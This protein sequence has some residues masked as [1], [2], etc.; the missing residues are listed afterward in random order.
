M[1]N[2]PASR[3]QQGVALIEVLVAVLI[4]SFGLLG[5]VGLQS[6]A[7][8]FSGNSEDRTIAASLA[9]EAAAQMYTLRTA[10]DFTG[11]PLT[12]WK[13]KVSDPLAGG[14]PG[15]VG[16]VTPVAATATTPA[17]VVIKVTWQPVNSAS[18]A[19]SSFT[20]DVLDVTPVVPAQV[21]P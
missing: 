21:I 3:P 19:L 14:L 4:F 5:L 18:G 6:R 7:I 15:G 11:T 8:Q 20:T 17:Y 16:S 10:A 12:N 13:N 2:R 1:N 9:A